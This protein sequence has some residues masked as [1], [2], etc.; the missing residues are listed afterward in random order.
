MTNQED[1]VNPRTGES[2]CGSNQYKHRWQS[3]HGDVICTDE[4]KCAPNWDQSVKRT[5]YGCSQPRPRR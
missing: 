2:E 3:A 5:D 1:Y 4:P